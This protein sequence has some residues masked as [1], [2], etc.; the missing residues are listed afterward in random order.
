MPIYTYKCIKCCKILEVSQRMTEDTF[1][2]HSEADS[3]T[4]C[5]GEIRR[6]LHAP[7]VKFIGAGFYEN[8]YKNKDSEAPDKEVS[9][10]KNSNGMKSM[11][12][13]VTKKD[14]KAE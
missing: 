8:D 7:A 12:A 4:T 3:G 5:N 11:K 10:T 2:T 13:T 6:Q 14:E 9:S 1:R